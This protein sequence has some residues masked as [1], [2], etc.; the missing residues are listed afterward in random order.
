MIAK[1][2]ESS[3]RF[4]QLI[5]ALFS[6]AE[7]CPVAAAVALAPAGGKP[8]GDGNDLQGSQ[9]T[10][11]ANAMIAALGC[12]LLPPL[13]S[14]LFAKPLLRTLCCLLKRALHLKLAGHAFA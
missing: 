12:D 8:L 1:K 11:S 5:D 9:V 10:L 4:N 13:C 7:L 6:P 14:R 2:Q 3:L